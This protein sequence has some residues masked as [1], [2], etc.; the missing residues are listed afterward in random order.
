MAIAQPK[1]RIFSLF[2]DMN[3][4]E[5]YVS[6]K[7][8]GELKRRW[9][10]Q[11]GSLIVS[12]F[13]DMHIIEMYP[14]SSKEDETPRLGAS[15]SPSLPKFYI[16]EMYTLVEVREDEVFS[17]FIDMNIIETYISIKNQSMRLPGW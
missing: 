5:M 9:G 10:P 11:P 15:S 16:I 4:I 14:R 2:I 8:D 1:S 3:I 17:L 7:R 13:I 6:R 12:L